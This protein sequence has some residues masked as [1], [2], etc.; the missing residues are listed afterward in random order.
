LCRPPLLNGRCT[1][2]LRTPVC[3]MTYTVSSGTLNSSTPY[4]NVWRRRSLLK[5]G[6]HNFQGGV[7]GPTMLLFIQC[8]SNTPNL[9]E[10]FQQFLIL[11]RNGFVDPAESYPQL[12]WSRCKIYSLYVIPCWG[13]RKFRN[14]WPHALELRSVAGSPKHLFPRKLA[15]AL[16]IWSFYGVAGIAR[17]EA[18]GHRPLVS[19]GNLADTLKS[20]PPAWVNKPNLT[21]VRQTL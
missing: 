15:S 21:A 13:P 1:S 7:W 19:G 3:E 6:S 2:L 14:A 5:S 9:M 10:I 18:L 17:M 12:V 4:H 11:I 8:S 20:L 16:R